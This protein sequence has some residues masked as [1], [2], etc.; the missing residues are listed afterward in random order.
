MSIAVVKSTFAVFS[1]L[2]PL[3]WCQHQDSGYHKMEQSHVK[4]YSCVVSNSFHMGA[5]PT[6]TGA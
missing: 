4:V 1:L 2:T 5:V 6:G 3:M